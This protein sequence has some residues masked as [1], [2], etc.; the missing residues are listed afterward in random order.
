MENT[1][2]NDMRR[3]QGRINA[4]N[5]GWAAAEVKGMSY[6]LLRMRKV[7][8]RIRAS[9]VHRVPNTDM[10][11]FPINGCSVFWKSFASISLS[12]LLR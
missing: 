5:C 8:G 10:M 7:A 11:P 9:E 12:T 4:Q 3:T 1:Q 2:L 6:G